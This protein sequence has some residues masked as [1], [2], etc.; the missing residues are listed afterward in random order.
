MSEKWFKFYIDYSIPGVY[1]FRS[2]IQKR[3]EWTDTVNQLVA[4]LNHLTSGQHTLEEAFE[5]LMEMRWDSKNCCFSSVCE[6]GITLEFWAQK[7]G[8]DL[9]L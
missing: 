4:I 2:Y 8:M 1:G 5:E 9:S 6:K 3:E 7:L